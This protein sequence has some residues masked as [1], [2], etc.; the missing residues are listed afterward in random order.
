MRHVFVDEHAA[1]E[2]RISERAADLAVDLDQVKRDVFPFEVCYCENS[3][4]GN[5]GELVV[6]FRNT[7]N[8]E[9]S[10]F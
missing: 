4:D 8:T 1:D 7:V 10:A 9:K 2:G 3:V 5:F 6:F